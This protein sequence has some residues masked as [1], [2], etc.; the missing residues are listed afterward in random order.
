MV[1][2]P[3][4]WLGLPALLLAG[5]DSPS[6]RFMGLVAKQ[7]SYEGST[8]SVRHTAYE[9]EVIRTNADPGARRGDILRRAAVAIRRASGCAIL[10][11]SLTGDVT[12]VR[13][14]LQCPGADEALRPRRPVEATC[15]GIEDPAFEGLID[16]ECEVWPS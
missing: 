7:V 13:A 5:C 14:D 1:F 11:R 4:L 2:F 12:V 15:V 3:A 16:L 8:F 10:P 6:P 9:A